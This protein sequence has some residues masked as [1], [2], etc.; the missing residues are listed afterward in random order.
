MIR[1][2]PRFSFGFSS[3]DTHD[4]VR[5]LIRDRY[6]VG[7]ASPDSIDVIGFT[8]TFAKTAGRISA[9]A[10]GPGPR[11]VWSRLEKLSKG[12]LLGRFFAASRD[13]LRQAASTLGVHHL[14]NLGGCAAQ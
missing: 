6:Y 3:F 10:F 11:L 12:R 14:A 7:S 4:V 9:K 13:R 8:P 1:Q 5:P 2:V